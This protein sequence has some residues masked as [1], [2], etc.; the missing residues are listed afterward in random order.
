MKID[1]ELLEILACP[2]C[3]SDLVLKKNE[4]FCKKCDEGFEIKNNI[5]RLLPPK[6]WASNEELII[7]KNVMNLFDSTENYDEYSH[8]KGIVG[9]Y[10]E[11]EERTNVMKNL[12]LKKGG[13][14]LDAAC[15]NGRFMKLT[16]N[17]EIIGLDLSFNLLKL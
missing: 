13:V 9:E 7:K 12:E 1:K 14:I 11:H 2:V 3:R 6:V 15:G 4:L 10:E 8:A 16:K 17:S 5:L